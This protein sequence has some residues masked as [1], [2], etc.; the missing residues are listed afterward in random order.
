MTAD[1]SLRSMSMT[2]MRLREKTGDNASTESI[3]AALAE[4]EAENKVRR[5]WVWRRFYF[6][7]VVVPVVVGVSILAWGLL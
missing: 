3:R 5:R 2:L 1:R 7:W 4:I 6:R